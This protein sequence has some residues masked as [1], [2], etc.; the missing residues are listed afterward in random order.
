[1]HLTNAK[2]TLARLNNNVS[3]FARENRELTGLIDAIKGLPSLDSEG[4]A[5]QKIIAAFKKD[6]FAVR[7]D[8]KK[9]IDTSINEVMNKLNGISSSYNVYYG[10]TLEK[11]PA[12]RSANPQTIHENVKTTVKKL[13]DLYNMKIS[14]YEYIQASTEQL[15]T[16]DLELHTIEEYGRMYYE[17]KVEVKTKRKM[18]FIKQE[19]TVVIANAKKAAVDKAHALA[20]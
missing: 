18:F 12:L 6:F 13:S 15:E 14:S 11:N 5:N 16:S 8:M 17:H 20:L 3:S 2:K 9:Q 1:M 4:L 10:G 7:S 19:P